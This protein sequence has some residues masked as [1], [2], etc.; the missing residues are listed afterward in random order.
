[1][2]DYIDYLSEEAPGA[3]GGYIDYLA[4]PEQES[5]GKRLIKAPYKVAEDLYKQ[6]AGFVKNIPTYAEQ[7]K[8]EIPGLFDWGH[9]QERGKQALA[10]LA[11]MGHGLMNAPRGI[12]DYTANRLNLIPEQWAQ[13]VPKPRDISQELEMFAGQPKNPGDALLRGTARNALSI[14]PAGKAVSALNPMKLTPKSI[15]KDILKSREKNMTSYGKQYEK[16]WNQ[17]EKKGF[18][19]ALYDVDMDMKSLKKYSPKDSIEGVLDFNTNPT[20]QNAHKAKSDL[21]RIQR[22]L[23]KK[24]TLTTAEQKQSKAV[25][26]AIDSVNNNMFKEPS[27]KINKKFADKY[28]E[29]QHGYKNNVIPYK[30]K[31]I[32]EYLRDEISE[33]ELVNS[34]S[35]RAF[36]RK[37]GKEHPEM[38]RRQMMQDHPY[39]TGGAGLTGLGWLYKQ[40]FG[41]NREEE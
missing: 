40:M 15:T 9:P 22:E 31:A 12:A 8:T 32:N 33:K 23:K 2:P 14:V 25:N 30:N 39:I 37:K 36:A 4:D 26:E 27:G 34:L 16:F 7:A 13:N 3:K 35:K 29:I 1:M 24:T 5:Y 20:L 19:N 18:G 28:A 11:E 17:A 41:D 21:L 6:G 10:G 38:K